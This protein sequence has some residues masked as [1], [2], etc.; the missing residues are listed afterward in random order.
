MEQ[1]IIAFEHEKNGRRIRDVLE[2]AGTAEGLLC[3]SADQVRRVARQLGIST[4][5]CG[6]K[7]PDGTAERLFEDLPPTCAMLIVAPQ[8]LLDLVQN[9]DILRLPAPASKHDLVAAVE[10]LLRMGRR[11]ERAARPHRSQADQQL[12]EQAKQ[13]LMDRFGIS[14][15]QAHRF[16]QKKS[17]DRGVKLVQAA[18]L[19]LDGL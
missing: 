6:Y 14:E 2:H 3:R 5:V 13:R 10:M 7:F 4:V 12:L 9:D 16:L 18:Q 19:V 15:E 11:L 8:G 17:M 1:V